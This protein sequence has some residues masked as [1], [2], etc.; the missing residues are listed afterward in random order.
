M[1][2]VLDIIVFHCTN[3]NVQQSYKTRTTP[4]I[5]ITNDD[6]TSGDIKNAREIER[7]KSNR[8]IFFKEKI[9]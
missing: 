6:N 3:A 1:G 4:T 8:I 9:T 2:K 5:I 7:E